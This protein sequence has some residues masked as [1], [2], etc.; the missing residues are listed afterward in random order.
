MRRLVVGALLALLSVGA[1]A[2]SLPFPI[3]TT[4]GSN[5]VWTPAMWITAWT[6][7]ADVTNVAGGSG[8]NFNAAFPTTGTAIGAF[9]AGN[10]VSV[11]AD[12]A[13]NLDVNCMSGCGLLPANAATATNQTA[14]QQTVAAGT[15]ATKSV[16]MGGI[17]NSSPITMTTGQ[18]AALQTDAN[19]YLKVNV[20][21]GGGTGGT[22]STYSAAFPSTGTAIGAKNGANMVFLGADGSNNLNVNCAVGCAGGTTS[23]AS[24]A[25]ATSSTNGAQVAWNYGFNGTTWDQLQVDGSKNLKVLVN[26]AL[27]AGTNLIGKVGIDQT[28][29]GTTNAISLAQIGANAVLTAGINGTQA[30]GG[31]TAAGSSIAAQ[32]VTV[33][34]RAQTAERGAVA[35]SQVVDMAFDIVGR[36]IIFPYA[37]KENLLSGNTSAITT[38]TNTSVISA[39]G[40]GVK[41]Y[42]TAFSCAN[43]GA[44]TS[45]IQFTSGSGG[46]VLWTSIIPAGGGSNMTLPTPVSTAAATALYLTTSTASTSMYCSI[47]GYAGT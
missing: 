37:N 27:T 16:L 25:V 10:M 7:K 8:S 45:L 38:A 35:N 29:V 13:G 30:I 2:Q 9:N 33:G 17:Y 39:Q 46:S 24:S 3:S 34:G 4:P 41:I 22:A 26:G 12:I 19:G 43:T 28:T 47:T 11:T 40:A 32:P 36:Q 6:S 23:N 20:S 14:I 15:V 1:Q 44:N 18:G 21:V 42:M 31:P 5:T